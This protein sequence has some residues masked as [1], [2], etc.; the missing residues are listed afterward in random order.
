M[1]RTSLLALTLLTA[2]PACAKESPGPAGPGDPG[3]GQVCTQIGCINGYRL[4]LKKA[5]PWTPGNYTFT[6][7]LD[8][9][10]VECKG[11][12]PLQACDTGPSLSCTPDGSLQ[13]GESGCALPP[14]QQGFSDIMIPGAPQ[15]V[16]LTIAQD[17]KPLHSADLT[18]NYVT[19]RP[20]GEQCEPTCS[21][22]AGEL[23]VP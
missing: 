12:L 23:A 20:N 21:S 10:V 8:G 17:G 9:K 7:E 22:A 2:L 6:A 3:G 4:E 15:R 16:R 5:T 19:T 14:D 18:P 11:A 13:I 1:S